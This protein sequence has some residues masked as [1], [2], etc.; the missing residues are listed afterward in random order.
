ME[1][2]QKRD[3]TER[4]PAICTTRNMT[5]PEAG[6]EPVFSRGC[7]D[8]DGLSSVAQGR[9]MPNGE[10]TLPRFLEHTP[11][12]AHPVPRGPSCCWTCPL[13][14]ISRSAIFQLAEESATVNTHRW[15][16]SP[17]QL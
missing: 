11:I 9:G 6:L 15:C 3:M 13:P 17:V 10:A 1:A 16:L 4:E 5:T 8:T 14:S 2:G 12:V 7:Y